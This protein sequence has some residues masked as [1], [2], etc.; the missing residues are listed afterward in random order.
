MLPMQATAA[1]APAPPATTAPVTAPLPAP[2]PLPTTVLVRTADGTQL[3]LPVPVT[4]QDVEN[5]RA[6]RE[7]L[8]N[9]LTSAAGRRKRLAE[10]LAQQPPGAEAVRAGLEGRLRVLDVRLAQL[11]SD[12]A[13]TGQQLSAAPEGLVSSQSV[14]RG[15]DMPEN[16]M[17]V[18]VVFTIF[19]LFPLAL[20]LA[21]NMWKKGTRSTV[22]TTMPPETSQRL[23]RL[24]QGVEAIAIEIERVSEGQRFVTRLLAEGAQ[25][26]KLPAS[27]EAE[28][29]RASQ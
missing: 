22:Q 9:Q 7:E 16:V 11:E 26:V 28:E 29:V 10:E 14:P 1:Q 27:R 21:R 20:T 8:S 15:G 3:T 17:T 18:S 5:L 23:E 25:G 6:R 2:A 13:A 4:R 19:I 24:E 12:I